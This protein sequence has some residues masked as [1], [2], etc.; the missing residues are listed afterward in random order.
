MSGFDWGET[1]IPKPPKKAAKPT[2]II[3][4]GDIPKPPALS[5]TWPVGLDIEMAL[6]ELSV[7]NK[8]LDDE[9]FCRQFDLTQDQLDY[10]KAHPAFRAQVRES[11]AQ[12]KD[13]NATIKRKSKIALEHYLD[14]YVPIWIQDDRAPVDSKTKLLQLLSKFAGIDAEE[15]AEAAKAAAGQQANSPVIRIELTTAPNTQ[16]TPYIIEQKAEVVK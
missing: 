15:K 9:D 16:A 10:I 8:I 1:I 5:N 2:A 7:G 4:Y 13:S 14:V 12:I 11:M 6:N 3:S